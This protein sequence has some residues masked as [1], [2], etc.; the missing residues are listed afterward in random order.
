M[1]VDDLGEEEAIAMMELVARRIDSGRLTGLQLEQANDD[2]SD[3]DSHI[4]NLMFDM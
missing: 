3:L 4:A 2:L 1:Y